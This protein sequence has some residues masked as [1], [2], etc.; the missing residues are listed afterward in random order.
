MPLN[1]CRAS[2][3]GSV[4]AVFKLIGPDHKIGVE[5]YNDPRVT[6][7]ISFGTKP[8]DKRAEMSSERTSLVVKK[9][10]VIRMFDAKRNT[11]VGHLAAATG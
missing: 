8:V 6:D 5:A 4:I 10:H 9:L 2:T 7:V 1:P 3:A 11:L